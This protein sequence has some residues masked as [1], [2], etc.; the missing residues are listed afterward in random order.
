MRHAETWNTRQSAWAS[1]FSG[2]SCRSFARA[3]QFSRSP[4]RWDHVCCGFLRSCTSVLSAGGN[5]ASPS[6]INWR[7]EATQTWTQ[8][9]SRGFPRVKMT[10][11][12]FWWR[13]TWT[14]TLVSEHRYWS[15]C[16]NSTCQRMATPSAL[17]SNCPARLTELHFGTLCLTCTCRQEMLG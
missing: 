11:Y 10:S 6:L 16:D 5:C 8:S 7:W 2:D 15:L 9:L 1:H 14:L 12:N 13:A 3:S 17:A 4:Q